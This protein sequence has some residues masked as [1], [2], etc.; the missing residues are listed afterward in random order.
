MTNEHRARRLSRALLVIILGLSAALRFVGLSWGL[1]HPPHLDEVWSMGNVVAMLKAGDLDHRLYQYPGLFMYTLAS[2]V[3]ALGRQRWDGPAPYLV[4]RAIVAAAGVLNLALLISGGV[5]ASG[6]PG[7][8]RRRR[9]PCRLA[10]RRRDE[11]PD[12]A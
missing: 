7:R 5:A 11:P 3:A 2:G 9:P 6:P 1:R 8:A 4:G 10:D 12:Q